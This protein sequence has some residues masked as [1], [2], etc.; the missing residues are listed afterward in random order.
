LPREDALKGMPRELTAEDVT[1]P[2][3]PRKST[4]VDIKFARIGD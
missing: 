2:P 3:S 1:G 4:D